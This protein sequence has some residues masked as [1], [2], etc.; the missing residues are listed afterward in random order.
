MKDNNVVRTPFPILYFPEG[1]PVPPLL[2]TEE[3]IHLLRLDV[4][5][6]KNPKFTLE[7]YRERGLLRG[8]QVGK[9]LRYS[10][11]DIVEFLEKQSDWT[12][13]KNTP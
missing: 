10:I 5:G 4:N 2:T 11:L 13:R 1:K 7:Y 12:N 3:L 6:P 8:I 9:H